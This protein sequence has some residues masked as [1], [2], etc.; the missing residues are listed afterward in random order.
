MQ[1]ES[2]LLLSNPRPYTTRLFFEPWAE[3][4]DFPPRAILNVVGYSDVPGE[5]DNSIYERGLIIWA[6][7]GSVLYIKI[8]TQDNEPIFDFQCLLQVP[9]ARGGVSMKEFLTKLM[10]KSE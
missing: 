7:Q 5:L 9:P 6:W 10:G 4:A 8:F 2:S 1:Y 3:E